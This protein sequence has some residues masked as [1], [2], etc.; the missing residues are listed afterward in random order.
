M[1]RIPASRFQA[2][3][4]LFCVLAP[5]LAPTAEAQ[6][7]IF[8]VEDGAERGILPGALAEGK[9]GSVVAADFDADGDIDLFLPTAAGEPHHLYRNRGDGTFDEI[10]AEAGLGGL[11]EARSALWIDVDG[12]DLL[13]LVTATDCHFRAV[14]CTSPLPSLELH[15]QLE[16]GRFTTTIRVVEEIN[17]NLHRGGF[18]AGDL[19]G[20]GDL[21]LVLGRW[22]GALGGDASGRFVHLFEGDGDG[23]LREMN[24][25]VTGLGLPLNGYYQPSLHDWSGDGRLDLYHTVDG[26]PNALFIN[27]GR[28][29]FEFDGAR[30]GLGSRFND[31]GQAL[32]D[33][34]ND[35]DFDIYITNIYTVTKYNVLLRNDSP[36]K[37][38]VL[39][40]TDVSHAAG[41]EDGSWGWGTTFFDAD[42]DG[43]LDLAETNGWVGV[44]DPSRFFE[45]VDPA[46]IRF[47]E[48]AAEVGL[49]DR[50]WGSALVAADLDRDGDLELIQSTYGERLR[51]YDN[52]TAEPGNYLVVRPRLERG[53]NRRAIGAVVRVEVGDQ[54]LVRR[55]A[56][57]TSFLGQEPAEAFFGLGDAQ[58]V[59]LLV[60]EWPDGSRTERRNVAAGQVFE[61]V[62]PGQGSLGKVPLKKRR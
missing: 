60:I 33:V 62:G 13:D 41:V 2:I 48:R 16:P 49:A 6:R 28:M 3:L 54:H 26:Q 14:R 37:G 31:M 11:D 59:D 15:R 10:A 55:V 51:I 35:G 5:L 44:D 23:D 39:K 9:G 38:G 7:G 8:F 42:N 45:N 53:A 43:D 21:D 40:F 57:G 47:V 12:D 50:E 22:G 34:D 20:D 18:A 58:R 52:R 27:R 56:A 17:N 30:Q 46:A 4:T 19:D 25:F 1:P 29:K 36:P 61:I 24:P 32:G